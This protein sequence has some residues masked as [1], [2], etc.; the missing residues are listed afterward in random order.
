MNV[1]VRVLFISQKIIEA[2]GKS[3]V[4]TTIEQ[5][6]TQAGCTTSSTEGCAHRTAHFTAAGKPLHLFQRLRMQLAHSAVVS[7][8]YV[9][10]MWGT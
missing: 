3:N 1:F 6:T 2:V 10:K 5:R 4:T 7:K 8:A 9:K